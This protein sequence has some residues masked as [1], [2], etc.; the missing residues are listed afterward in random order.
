VGVINTLLMK[1]RPVAGGY[2]PVP[3]THVREYAKKS[4]DMFNPGVVDEL[5]ARMGGFQ[6][7]R[8]LDLGAGPGQYAIEFA[9]R[10][11][12]VTWHDISR[13]Y[14]ELVQELARENGVRL[15]FSLGYLEEAE[16]LVDRPFDL[17]FNRICWMYCLNDYRFARLFHDLVRPGGW[18]YV[19]SDYHVAGMG[20][21]WRLRFEMNRWT[22]WKLGHIIPPR[23]RL[24][25]YFRGFG[26]MD[27]EVQEAPPKE[28]LFL[29][30]RQA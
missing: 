1:L 16:R 15:D 19:N 24:E 12:A 28:Q 10:G 20:A 21:V 25:K 11:A 9:R 22:G 13:N 3:V 14:M 2:D 27:V 5:E 26:D 7:K 18:G 29:R 30:R 17:V 8:V 6:G 23:G 4:W